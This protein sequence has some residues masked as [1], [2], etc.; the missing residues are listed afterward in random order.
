[1][2]QDTPFSSVL[3]EY[4]AFTYLAFFALNKKICPYSPPPPRTSWLKEAGSPV[5]ISQRKSLW[6]ALAVLTP[7]IHTAVSEL[8]QVLSLFFQLLTGN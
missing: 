8:N 7:A 4:A 6:K 5:S 1:M 2:V 3:A